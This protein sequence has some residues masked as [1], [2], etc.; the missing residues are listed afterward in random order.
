MSKFYLYIFI[1]ILFHSCFQAPDYPI[2]PSIE[3]RGT[4]GNM[5]IVDVDGEDVKIVVYYKDGDGD[6]GIEIDPTDTVQLKE[7]TNGKLFLKQQRLDCFGNDLIDTIIIPPVPQNGSV[8]DIDGE[9]K[10]RINNYLSCKE[11]TS[12]KTQDTIIYEVFL[13]DRNNNKSNSII[14]DAII[15]S[16]K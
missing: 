7:A 16:C 12:L 5:G 8:K 2:I 15:F 6:I 11:C 13:Y 4:I 9:I 1:I 3:Y 10:I 14:T